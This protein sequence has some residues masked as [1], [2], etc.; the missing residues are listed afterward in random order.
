LHTLVSTS[1]GFE[2]A[3]A[4]LQFRGTGEIL[5]L[6]QSGRVILRIANLTTDADIVEHTL[7]DAESIIAADPQLRTP[8]NRATR[9]EFLRL[10]RD[11]ESYL[12]VG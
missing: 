1:D 8:P 3:K 4:D 6:K 10:Y 5:G 2:I 12:H 11:E 9:E 7:H